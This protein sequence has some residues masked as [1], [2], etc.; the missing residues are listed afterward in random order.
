MFNLDLKKGKQ[1]AATFRFSTGKPYTRVVSVNNFSGVYV[2]VY[3]EYMAER[4]PVYQRLDL[5]YSF[6]SK[7]TKGL[8]YYLQTVNTFNCKNVN[9]YYYNQDYTE[10]YEA[11]TLPFTVLGGIKYYF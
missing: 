6:P 5:K 7:K 3:G 2:P 11:V 8:E 4:M 1:L 9:S 10:R